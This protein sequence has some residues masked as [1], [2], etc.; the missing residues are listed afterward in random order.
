MGLS[1]GIAGVITLSACGSSG[2]G[3][4]GSLDGSGT[5]TPSATAS[6]ST[7]ATPSAGASASTSAG[8]G[9]TGTGSTGGTGGS[10]SGSGG[11]GGTGGTGTGGTG[12]GG[13]LSATFTLTVNPS[14]PGGTNVF[15]VAGN[16]STVTWTTSGATGVTIYLDGGLYT[17]YGPNGSTS[18]PFS[19]EMPPTSPTQTHVYKLVAT[20]GSSTVERSITATA[21]NAGKSD[22]GSPMGAPTTP[23]PA[24]PAPATPAPATPAPA[25]PSV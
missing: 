18:L 8:T 9:S 23:A 25:T 4:L 3:S 12:G 24:T 16:D 17:N 1:L 11:T 6:T 5:P 15:P 7:S 13:G 21:V 14:C 19:C 10:G 2:G 20:D 22:V